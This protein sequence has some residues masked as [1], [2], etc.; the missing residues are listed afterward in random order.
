MAAVSETIV[1]II[2]VGV[3]CFLLLLTIQ[4]RF[5]IY[6]LSKHV[7]KSYRIP[8][9]KIR[10]KLFKTVTT[11]KLK[12]SFYMYS[13]RD[14]WL[15]DASEPRINTTWQLSNKKGRGREGNVYLDRKSVV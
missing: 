15:C 6:R 8:F 3:L 12:S 2:A 5:I 14:K 11:K 13:V 7:N 4:Y 10:K 9:Y 1:L